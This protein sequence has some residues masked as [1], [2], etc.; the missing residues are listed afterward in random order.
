VPEPIPCDWGSESAY[1]AGLELAR[2]P[3]VTA[4]LA[5][6]DELALGVVRAMHDSGR[7]VPGSLSLIGFDDTPMSKFLTPSLSTSRLD[8]AALGRACF[9]TLLGVIDPGSAA[10]PVPPPEPRLIIRESTGPAPGGTG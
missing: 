5:G 9:A 3:G 1:A 6:N 7:D 4:V 10:G 8:F 2:D